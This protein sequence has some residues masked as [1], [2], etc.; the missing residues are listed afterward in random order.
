MGPLAPHPLLKVEADLKPADHLGDDP[1]FEDVGFVDQVRQPFSTAVNSRG[2][3]K[4]RSPPDSERLRADTRKTP[5]QRG[6]GAIQGAAFRAERK[7]G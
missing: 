3:T 2:T 7:R 5:L 4:P 6:R 1:Q